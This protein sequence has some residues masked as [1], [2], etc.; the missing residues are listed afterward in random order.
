MNGLDIVRVVV[1][2]CP[3][4]AFGMNVIGHN[5]AVVPEF[6]VADGAFPA[7]LSNFAIQQ[8]AHFRWRA[9]FTKSSGVM[10]VFNVLHAA[11]QNPLVSLLLAA[12]AEA[13]AVDRTEL[14]S[15]EFHR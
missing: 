12:A 15:A 3:S 13:R 9:E 8:L 1:S 7:L 11:P 5:V 2:P 4:Q 14:V 6:L 10:R